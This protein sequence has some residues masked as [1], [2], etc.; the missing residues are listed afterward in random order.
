[1]LR[2]VHFSLLLKNV[3]LTGRNRIPKFRL[4]FVKEVDGR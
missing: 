4:A 1:M 3:S 2:E